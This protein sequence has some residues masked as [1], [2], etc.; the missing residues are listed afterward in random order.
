MSRPL[1]LEYP[2]AIYHVTSRGNARSD[3]YITQQDR[4]TFLNVLAE[5]CEHYNWYCYAWCLM[6]NHYH[7]VIETAD[8]NLS[9]GMRQLN[10]AYTQSFNR[11]HQRVGH[12]FQGRYK[13]ILIEKDG[14][15]LEV[16]RYV[17]LNP[18]RAH[19]VRT[20]GQ[21]PW[22]SYRAMINKVAAPDWLAKG[23]VLGHFGKR[24]A[25]AQKH[26]INFIR[27]AKNQTVIWEQLR[28]QLYLG[29][30][31]FVRQQ[32]K[33]RTTEKDLSEIPKIQ[34]QTRIKPLDYYVK[35][36]RQRN[37]AIYVAFTSGGYSQKEIADC[38]KLHYS[39]ISKIIK[40][41]EK[42]KKE[43]VRV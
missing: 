31:Q 11:V 7:L 14:Y 15:L 2:G 25:T 24:E 9:R 33:K 23:W 36:H 22:S 16:I 21:Y 34:R 20:A 32:Q 4:H 18:V 8:A 30:E 19:M 27:D 28:Q 17:L 39:S 26:F 13:A 3:I 12:L 38:F 35:K 40:Q 29:D 6:T 10:G 5:V 42:K 1:R 41:Y 43:T 37:D